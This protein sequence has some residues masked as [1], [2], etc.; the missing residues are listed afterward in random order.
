MAINEQVG[1]REV[2]VN[3]QGATA[4]REWHCLWAE[5]LDCVKINQQFPGE[6]L[7]R[8]SEITYRPIGAPTG[9]KNPGLEY[10]DCLVIADY[11]TFQKIDDAP[12]ESFEFGGEVLETGLGRK[13]MEAGTRIEQSLGVF[14]PELIYTLTLTTATLNVS[15]IFN[16][17]A[18]VNHW[19]F[20]GA[21]A[22]TMLFEGASAESRFDYERGI[23]IY[24]C[25]Y[26][27]IYRPVPWNVVWRAPRQARDG[28]GALQWDETGFPVYEDGPAGWGG[29]DRPIPNLYAEADFGPML[30]Q[31][32]R[33]IPPTLPRPQDIGDVVYQG[34]A[35]FG[36]GQRL[37]AVPL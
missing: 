32:G 3:R 28:L 15:A 23:Y 4:H 10:T 30:G 1:S 36:G 2:R 33:R 9:L 27:F 16:N 21:P 24:R 7:L 35:G 34:G 13:W 12:E 22:Q 31:P 11:S 8:C 18:C 19:P 20:Y 14:Y 25:T 17:L 37:D 29:W 6:P 26:R 5:R